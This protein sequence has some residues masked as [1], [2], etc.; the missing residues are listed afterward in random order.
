MCQRYAGWHASPSHGIFKF[1]HTTLECQFSFLA[2]RLLLCL[3]VRTN[4]KITTNIIARIM[5]ISE[6][7]KPLA[8]LWALRMI[9]PPCARRL[10]RHRLGLREAR[11]S[12]AGAED[13]RAHRQRVH[14]AAGGA[15]EGA[16]EPHSLLHGG[17]FHG[18]VFRPVPVRP[19]SGPPNGGQ[20]AVFVSPRHV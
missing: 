6:L 9:W 12:R 16:G 3:S 2:C 13:G 20:D 19:V 4:I 1:E 14:P 15:P 10:H 11:G 18:A 7:S 8:E 17:I 5:T